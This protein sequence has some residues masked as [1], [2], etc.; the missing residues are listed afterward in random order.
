MNDNE[1]VIIITT[2][3]MTAKFTITSLPVFLAFTKITQVK[4]VNGYILMKSVRYGNIIFN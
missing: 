1:R 4:S 2:Y 3:W